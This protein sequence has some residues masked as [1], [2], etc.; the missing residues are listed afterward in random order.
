MVLPKKIE[1][2][3][4]NK[5]PFSEIGVNQW[6]QD[7][8]TSTI[9]VQ[10]QEQDMILSSLYNWLTLRFELSED[11]L[12]YLFSL[13]ASFRN[14]LAQ[15]IAFAINNQSAITL[16]KQTDAMVSSTL[17]EDSVKVTEY[18]SSKAQAD[19]PNTLGAGEPSTPIYNGKL[20]IRIYYKLL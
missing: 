15:E 2:N 20:I 4:M 7:L 1:K 13:S 17:P 9:D 10:V 11:Q 18:E 5:Y 12:N 19:S 3:K 16:D 14:N 6:L 8:Y